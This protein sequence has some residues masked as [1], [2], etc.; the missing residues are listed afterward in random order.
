MHDRGQASL[1]RSVRVL[2]GTLGPLRN[3]ERNERLA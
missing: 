1:E 2:N 3:G